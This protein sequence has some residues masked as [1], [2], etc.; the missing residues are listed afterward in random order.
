M[1]SPTENLSCVAKTDAILSASYP[2][3][4]VHAFK[5]NPQFSIKKVGKDGWQSASHN[6]N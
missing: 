4:I 3:G 5:L 1:Y 2:L 6:I